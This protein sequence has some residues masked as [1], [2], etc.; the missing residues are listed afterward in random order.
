MFPASGMHPNKRKVALPPKNGAKKV[1]EAQ[2]KDIL[3]ELFNELDQNDAEDLNEAKQ[4]YTDNQ[5]VVNSEGQVAFSKHEEMQ[6]KAANAQNTNPQSAHNQAVS[7][8][9]LV[10]SANPFS[11]KRQHSEITRAPLEPRNSTNQVAAQDDE[12]ISMNEEMKSALASDTKMQSIPETSMENASAAKASG[13]ATPAE[14][15]A[16]KQAASNTEDAWRQL[17]QQN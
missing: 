11:K 4:A 17:K 1:N 16:A 10:P 3:G 9:K 14:Q 8:G 15:Q 13:D 5:Q 12:D 6:F 7:T 2:S